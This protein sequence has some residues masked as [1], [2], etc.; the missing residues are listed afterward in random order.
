MRSWRYILAVAVW[1]VSSIVYSPAAWSTDPCPIEFDKLVG[2]SRQAERAILDRFRVEDIDPSSIRR[3]SSVFFLRLKSG[4]EFWVRLPVGE[5][6][7][8]ANEVFISQMVANSGNRGAAVR[9][10]SESETKDLAD[11]I[12]QKF[13]IRL[14]QGQRQANLVVHYPGEQGSNYQKSREINVLLEHINDYYFEARASGADLS[15]I[16]L[17]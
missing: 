9:M 3:E 2:F 8:L 1:F 6:G 10:I 5:R 7:H 12:S 4:E 16:F 14:L 17:P 15:G 13:R 11:L